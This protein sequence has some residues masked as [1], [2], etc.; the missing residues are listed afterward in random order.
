[1]KRPSRERLARIARKHTQEMIDVLRGL[2]TGAENEET[3][4]RAALALIHEGWGSPPTSQELVRPEQPN[5]TVNVGALAGMSAYG[6]YT[7]H[8][9]NPGLSETDQQQLIEYIRGVPSNAARPAPD[10]IDVPPTVVAPASALAEPNPAV[11]TPTKPT[12]DARVAPVPDPTGEL[13][14]RL[15]K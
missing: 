13:W 3:R 15:G 7:I 10:V 6:A 5:V 11:P 4:R 2:A 8:A 1:V 14:S 12:D 9:Q